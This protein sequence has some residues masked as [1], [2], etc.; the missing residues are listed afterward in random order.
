[1]ASKSLTK[2]ELLDAISNLT[3]V[4]LSELV[5]ALEEKFGVSASQGMMMAGPV[6]T[7]G[8]NTQEAPVEEKTSFDLVLKGSGSKKLEVIKAI[9]VILPELNLMD[10]KAMVEASDS[11]EK[12]V[13]QALN[14]DDAD[15]YLKLLKDAGAVVELK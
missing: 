10:A 2:D 4:E 7:Q 12:I 11:A 9:R 14:K 5:K 13:K 6:N 15:K 8:S 3:V 1:M